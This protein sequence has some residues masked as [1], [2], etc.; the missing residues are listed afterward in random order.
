MEGYFWKTLRVR[1]EVLPWWVV[2]LSAASDDG[3]DQGDTTRGSS[4]WS[5][6]R[7]G[8]NHAVHWGHQPLSCSPM[9]ELATLWDRYRDLIV[10]LVLEEGHNGKPAPVTCLGSLGN[11]RVEGNAGDRDGAGRGGWGGKGMRHP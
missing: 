7:K 6:R 2:G 11:L 3:A 9:K 8:L 4:S 10:V 1:A 5:G